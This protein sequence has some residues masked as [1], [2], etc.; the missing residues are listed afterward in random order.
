MVQMRSAKTCFFLVKWITS[1]ELSTRILTAV[2]G[3]TGRTAYNKPAD[4]EAAIYTT[5]A[6]SSSVIFLSEQ[7]FKAHREITEIMS[8]KKG[9]NF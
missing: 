6:Y 2:G 1:Q 5:T 9:P 8:N 7:P 4:R 3:G